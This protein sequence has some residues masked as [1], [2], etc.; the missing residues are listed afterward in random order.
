MSAEAEGLSVPN[1]ETLEP[2]G[3]ARIFQLGGMRGPEYVFG[4]KITKLFITKCKN[5]DILK[6]CEICDLQKKFTVN[7]KQIACVL[8]ALC[9]MLYF[10]P[11]F[12]GGAR[13]F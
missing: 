13:N 4:M 3:V 10:L 2:R 8:R 5:E 11:V 1:H 6:K 7:G 9:K 12:A